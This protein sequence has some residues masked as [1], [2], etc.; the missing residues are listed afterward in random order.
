MRIVDVKTIGS[1]YSV[2][3][4]KLLFLYTA[5]YLALF[6]SGGNPIVASCLS[7]AIVVRPIAGRWRRG[8]SRE[9][10]FDLLEF[11][12]LASSF[13]NRGISADS[14]LSESLARAR[15]NIKIRRWLLKAS[16]N[17][18]PPELIFSRLSRKTYSDQ[19]LF[20]NFSNALVNGKYSIR[21]VSPLILILN[22]NRSLKLQ[23][24]QE[25]KDAYFRT[26]ILL[27]INSMSMSFLS[28]FYPV[29]SIRNLALGGMDIATMEL[30][31]S[32]MLLSL[33]LSA[34]ASNAL[35]GLSLLRTLIYSLLTYGVS[36]LLFKGL[37]IMTVGG[38]L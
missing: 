32:L 10:T 1:G 14:V 19:L 11:M 24:E 34:V 37:F 12:K 33:S 30:T 15:P 6:L 7:L 31:I 25:Q 16:A 27:I 35:K 8:V 5:L 21:D 17:G 20:Q 26:L 2:L 9:E 3:N 13:A 29:L 38:R 28:S 36:H 23:S 18:N 22:E 4:Y